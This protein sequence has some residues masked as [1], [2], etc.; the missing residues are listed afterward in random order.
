[1]EPKLEPGSCDTHP[2]A[3]GYGGDAGLTGSLA[4][5]AQGV[6]DPFLN[7]ALVLLPYHLSCS[8]VINILL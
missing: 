6:N 5:L 8:V 2:E 1:M 4:S 3:L 7:S